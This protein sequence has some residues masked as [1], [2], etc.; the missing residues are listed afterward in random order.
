M[1]ISDNEV[2]KVLEAQ[3][4]VEAIV[5]VGEERSRADDASLV[6]EVVAQVMEMPD[7]ED[8]IAELRAKIAS[9]SY[10]PT[11]AEIAEAMVRRA[12]ADRIR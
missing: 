9:G 4:V 7:R 8:R 12:I 6:Q 10:N 5:E 11:G 1:Q 3:K 2:K